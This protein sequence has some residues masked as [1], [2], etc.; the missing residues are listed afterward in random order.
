MDNYQIKKTPSFDYK[1]NRQNKYLLNLVFIP[2]ILL[3]LIIS[4]ISYN[5]VAKL[6]KSNSWVTHTYQVIQAIDTSL[7]KVVEMEAR[8]RAFLLTNDHEFIQD[9]NNRKINLNKSLVILQNLVKDNPSQ[10]KRTNKLI[11]LINL[12]I[13][14]L[15]K[16]LKF[17]AEKKFDT[18]EGADLF[19]HNLD[20]SNRVKSLAREIRSIELVLLNERNLA[21]IKN[22]HNTNIILIIGNII[23]LTIIFVA[24]LFVNIQLTSRIEAEKNL[25]TFEK[26]LRS[27]IENANDMIAAL[28]KKLEYI[29]FNEVYQKEFKRVFG[30]TISI[31]MSLEQAL[32]ELTADKQKLLDSWKASLNGDEYTKN[33]DFEVD[34]EKNFYEITSSMVTDDENK[35]TGAVHI[36]RNITSRMQE[37]NELKASYEQL[38]IGMQALKEKNKQITMLVEISDIML[39]CNS[40]AELSDVIAK[41]CYRMFNF[42]RGYL[43]VMHPSKNYLESA[44]TWGDPDSQDKFFSPDACWG[45][46]RGRIQFIGTDHEELICN[47]IQVL[48]NKNLAYLCIPLMAQND[49]YG[50]LFMEILPENIEL[51]SDNQQLLLNAF[52]ELSALALA[53]VRLRENLRYQ[54]IRDPLTG[55]YNRRYLE[56]FLFK[57]IN[58]AERTH[59]P[60]TILMLDLDHFKKINDT[61]GHEAGD[62]I[63]KQLGSILQSDIRSGDI[64]ARFGGEEFIIVFYNTDTTTAKKRAESIRNAVALIQTKYG[65]QPIGP[66]TISIGIA[67]YPAHGRTAPELIENADKALYIAKK[68]G[69]NQVVVFSGQ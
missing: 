9:F 60:L 24:I 67:E 30:T 52:A 1:P 58:Q 34:G 22:A 2:A 46:R 21:L 25:K 27:I 45:I 15:E 32:G 40:I 5:Q 56:D 3:I 6:I 53:N 20:L 16:V 38:D 12:R 48:D 23:S 29:I 26:R 54:S 4:I 51:Y 37:Q 47:H 39:A 43:Y 14:G 65:A 66:I 31:G 18:A 69:R 35:I 33:I 50:L 8:Q 11:T 19:Q 64:A 49:I 28:N 61:Y 17:K 10:L 62:T 57:Q 41:Y 42:A 55:L 44:G 68:N 59:E 36:I 7:Y 63:L 13:D